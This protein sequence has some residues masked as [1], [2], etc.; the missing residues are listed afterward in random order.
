MRVGELA[1][2]FLDEASDSRAGC[3]G[4]VKLSEELIATLC[5]H[6][7]GG[8]SHAD[9]FSLQRC[10]GSETRGIL[11]FPGF[12]STSVLRTRPAHCSEGQLM[13]LC[14]S[15][16]LHAAV[17]VCS[18]IRLHHLKGMKG[19]PCSAASRSGSRGINSKS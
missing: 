12:S 2:F 15:L 6:S 18:H 9:P 13:Q 1:R 11:L 19:G 4:G 14:T 16:A 5:T 17:T 10:C 7:R 8:G 3:Y